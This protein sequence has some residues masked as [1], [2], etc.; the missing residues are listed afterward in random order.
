MKI[1]FRV[2]KEAKK[3][4]G[5]LILAAC[6][7]IALTAINLIAPRLLSNMTA[8]VSAGMT[9]EGL[10]QIFRIAL[11]LLGLFLLKILFRYLANFMA[12]KA[13]WHLVEEL[14]IKVYST[15]QSFS[16]DF[17]RKNQ[18]GD[19]VSR[20]IN[21]TAQFELLYAHLLPESITNTITLFG[22]MGILF[23]I[24][25]RLALLTCIPIP[26]ILFSGWIFAKKVRPN[27]RTM[28][29]SL[30]ELSGQLQDNYSGI[31]EIQ[32]FGQ[33]EIV[34]E[35]T[36]KKASV[37]TTSMLHALNLSAIF[38][39]SVEF[40]T[41]L[42]TVIVV[43]FGGYLA[44]TSQL[45]VSDIVAFMLYLS[46]FYAP[47]TGI[48]NLLEQLQQALAGSERVIEVLDYP[49]AI[50]DSHDAV[51]IANPK[52]KL[53]FR[54]VGFSYIPEVPI[55]KDISLSIR[56]GQMIALVG[57][58]GVGKTTMTQLISRF[59]DPTEGTI[60][61]DDI[62]LKRISLMD[63]RSHIA[64][65][66]QDT[67]LFNGTI[68]ENI[69]FARPGSTQEDIEA[70]AM[71]ARIH[72]D[73][74]SMPSG[75]DTRVGERGARLSG[76][77]KQRIA[78]ARAVICRAPILVLDEA[79]ASVD[80]QTE[81]DIQLAIQE[82]TGTRTIIAIAHRLSTIQNADRIFVFEEGEITQVGTH[83]ELSSVP[84]LYQRMCEV[85]SKGAQIVG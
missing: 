84:G 51:K 45:E 59:Y 82:L 5:L 67:F 44:F 79:T 39:P 77:Q 1:L 29:K 40:L 17:F 80:V 42:G 85:Q 16:M 61:M 78:I 2:L 57:A 50:Q 10:N 69:S 72:E 4:T 18:T 73:I 83:S 52:G 15:L 9:R 12:H 74:L 41:S 48:A 38:H 34:T 26:F 65:V 63:L 11:S 36:Q 62:D 33:Q 21:D 55:L 76:G 70:A 22:V 13:A 58:T 28:Q 7:T 47:I 31:Q 49:V 14:R 46:L 64:V 19:L 30:G 75:Y 71:T 66:L 8:I 35:K 6:S 68:G 54:H 27:F 60:L 43:G 25:A 23:S 20:T 3:Y 53:E 24:N 81:R 37:L 32:V 56:P